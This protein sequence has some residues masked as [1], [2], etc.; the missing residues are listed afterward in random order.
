MHKYI[1]T[2]ALI[3][4][5]GLQLILAQDKNTSKGIMVDP[6]DGFYEE[7]L[8]TVGDT[9]PK[10]NKKEFIVDF[11][12]M[13]IP[14]SVDEFTSCWYNPPV[15]QGNTGTCWS[16]STTSFLESE[17]Y[18]IQNKKVKLSE[19]YTVYCEYIEKT[20]RYISERGNS[21]I[22]EGS[23]ANAV[24]RIWQKY[25][26]M[27]EEAYSGLKSGQKF[28]NHK[29]MI[30]EIKG[31]LQNLKSTNAWDETAAV[32]TV[33]AILDHYMGAP[34][35]EFSYL[36]INYTPLEFLAN[37]LRLNPDDYV[38][39]MSLKEKP[40][41]KQV[42]YNVSDNWWHD[43]SYYNVPLDLF[44]SSIKSSIKNGYSMCIGGDVSEPGHDGWHNVALV[45]SFDIPSAYINEDAR[46]MR[47]DNGTTEDDHGI[48]LA[49]YKN[50]NGRTWF[51]IKDSGAGSRNGNAKG[52]YFFD[53]D[54]VKLKIMDFMVHKDAVKELLSQ[55]NK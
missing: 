5:F 4:S 39:I 40:Y 36:R 24:T 22:S 34:P 7:I 8:R 17:V 47:F 48:H 46:E 21:E 55:F 14:K 2:I 38:D 42:Q 31:Y 13:D 53:E 26:A 1:L 54:Y 29:D 27:P 10:T 28:H 20:K 37:Y 33:K 12:G 9:V 49:G 32:N 51:L 25:G 15:S 41:F 19:M 45:P 6:K 50:Q 18:R 35:K 52:F 16:F 30:R 44:M 3:M 43:S 23:E 11:T